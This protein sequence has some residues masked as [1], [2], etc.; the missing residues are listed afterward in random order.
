MCTKDV[1][2]D[3]VLEQINSFHYL[4]IF[5]SNNYLLL[6]VNKIH[7]FNHMYTLSGEHRSQQVKDMLKCLQSNGLFPNF[8]IYLRIRLWLGPNQLYLGC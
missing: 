7:K 4:A 3:I 8:F 5:L 1:V 6:I 2:D